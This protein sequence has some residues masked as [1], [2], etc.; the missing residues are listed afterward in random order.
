MTMEAD[1]AAWSQ[2]IEQRWR[3]MSDGERL[4]LMALCCRE[5]GAIAKRYAVD[6]A[7]RCE[8]ERTAD[9]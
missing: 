9:A 7:P 4:R 8:C 3:E 6:Q 2:L 1:L 5:C